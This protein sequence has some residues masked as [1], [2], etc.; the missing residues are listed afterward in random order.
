RYSEVHLPQVPDY[1]ALAE[2]YGAVGLRATSVDDV[3]NVI[4]KAMGVDDRPCVIDF[5][6]DDEEM[7]FP[8]VPAGA[9]NDEILVAPNRRAYDDAALL[10]DKAPPV[11]EAVS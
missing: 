5:R 11:K 4:D 9:S 2:A 10:N 6:V 3:E 1:V 8:M 7:C